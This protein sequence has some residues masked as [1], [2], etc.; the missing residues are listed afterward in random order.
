M[1]DPY[2]GQAIDRS[3]RVGLLSVRYGVGPDDL[4]TA[5]R[6]AFD[7]LAVAAGP[8]V[9]EVVPGGVSGGPPQVG[10]TD[11]IGVGIAAIVLVVTFGSLV[12]AGMTLL[13]AL[14]GVLVGMS[15]L[16]AVTAFVN[17]SSTAPILALMLGLAVGIDYALFISSRPPHATGGRDDAGGVGRAGHRYGRVG[18]ALRG[19]DGGGGAGRA[20]DRRRGRS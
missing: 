15:G 19:R 11:V 3:G 10:A 7:G 5:D 9:L 16:L 1:V 2:Q 18:G 14:I 6:D 4:T 17:V 12:A 8:G 20:V 13:T